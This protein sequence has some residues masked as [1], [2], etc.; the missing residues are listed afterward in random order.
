MVTPCSAANPRRQGT[1][2]ADR[3]P[4]G[5]EFEAE[6]HPLGRLEPKTSPAPTN[7]CHF[8]AKSQL[9]LPPFRYRVD[10]VAQCAARENALRPRA[11]RGVPIHLSKLAA[12]PG[13]WHL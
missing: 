8:P 1:L 3:F 6:T 5:E 4:S 7:P 9:P 2:S 13:P 11:R 12:R 10:H